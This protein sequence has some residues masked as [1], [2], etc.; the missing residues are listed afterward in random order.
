MRSST[1]RRAA[2]FACLLF[3][4]LMMLAQSSTSAQN[5]DRDMPRLLKENHV[6]SVSVARVERGR[7]VMERAFG[8]QDAMTAA[9]THTL[10][11]IASLTKPITAQVAMR[12]LSQGVFTL[13]EPMAPVWTDPDVADDPRRNLLTPRIA[14]T[15]QT[16]F[17]NWRSMTGG[18]LTF[19]FEPGTK[20]GYSGEGFEYLARFMEKKAGE[21]L[22]ASAKR[23]VFDPLGMKETSFT[24]QPWFAGRIAVPADDKGAWLTPNFAEKPISADLVYTTAHDY[25]LLLQAVIENTGITAQIAAERD[26]IQIGVQDDE[27]P[28]LA[29]E[30]CPSA[31]GSG[32]SWQIL[33]FG[34]TIIM[35]HTGHDP[36][37]HTLAYLVPAD[38]SGG[39]ILTNG[40]N[41]RKLYGT[42]LQDMGAPEPFTSAVMALMK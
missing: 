22:D 16:G 1:V 20:Y 31:L 4:R 6:P 14:L 26:R 35:M 2:S 9:T 8:M 36:G 12:L 10:Y 27:C 24:R 32:L 17:A 3:L 38:G 39:V 11:N 30:L 40:D 15:H 19:Q 13:D 34:K 29:P 28:R 23:L 25:A 42:I 7:I 5:L 21:P 33:R 37:V 41:G 18:K